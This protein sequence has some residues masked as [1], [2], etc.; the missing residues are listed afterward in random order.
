M[1]NGV[2]V[3]PTIWSAE[4]HDPDIKRQALKLPSRRN[5]K[6]P[7]NTEVCRSEHGRERGPDVT[8]GR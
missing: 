3:K 2:A 7:R 6:I 1:A 8:D 5:T 4:M